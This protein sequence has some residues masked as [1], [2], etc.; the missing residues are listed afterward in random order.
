MLISQYELKKINVLVYYTALVCQ[1]VFQITQRPNLIKKSCSIQKNGLCL[2]DDF[3]KLS[4]TLL[5]SKISR[6]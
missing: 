4:V 6:T 1:S 2:T 3:P 5:N